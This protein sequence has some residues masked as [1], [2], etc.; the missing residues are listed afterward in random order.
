[1]PYAPF[2]GTIQS[3]G[4]PIQAPKATSPFRIAVLGD[5][6]GRAHRGTIEPLADRKPIRVDRDNLDQVME[7][8]GVEVRLRRD[9]WRQAR[10]ACGG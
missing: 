8:F 1:M 5:F 4:E 10:A 3:A 2:F 6:S 7:R 9:G